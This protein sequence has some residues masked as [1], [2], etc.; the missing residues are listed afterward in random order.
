VKRQGL[1]VADARKSAAA[2]PVR[3]CAAHREPFFVERLD[4]FGR[5]D[6]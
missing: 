2:I 6:A 5:E 1:R 4:D 3:S